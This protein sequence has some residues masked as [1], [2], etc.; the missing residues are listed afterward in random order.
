M[1]ELS[2]QALLKENKRLAER[3]SEIEGH[4]HDITRAYISIGELH[5]SLKLSDVYAIILDILTEVIGVRSCGV[6]VVDEITE[7]LKLVASRGP[8]K[9]EIADIYRVVNMGV[10]EEVI[11][12]GQPYIAAPLCC[13]PFLLAPLRDES[14]TGLEKNVIGLFLAID[15]LPQ[16]K[17]LTPQDHEL[18]SSL[19][20]HAAV[21]IVGARLY[22]RYVE[23]IAEIRE[24]LG[25]GVEERGPSRKLK[26]KKELKDELSSITTQEMAMEELMKANEEII[27]LASELDFKNV[28]LE[29]AKKGLEEKV[30]ERT[31]ELVDAQERLVRQEKLTAMGKLAGIVGHEI[32]GP[33]GTIKNSVEFLKIRLGKSLDEKVRSHLSILLE[34]VNS[35]DEIIGDILDFAR[36]KEPSL[37]KADA[38]KIVKKSITGSINPI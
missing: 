3:V 4:L 38:N 14:L 19:A 33:L 28:Q 10:V 1:K 25:K 37:T 5:R 24:K 27:T 18:L 20:E 11:K 29:K 16:K 15:L 36:V 13:Y 30:K 31:K 9:E 32:R 17:E 26:S 34:E 2:K 12:S 8:R 22:A 7:E 35:S 23:G 21:S 6:M